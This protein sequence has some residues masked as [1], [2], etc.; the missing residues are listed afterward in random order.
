MSLPIDQCPSVAF[1]ADI[2][3]GQNP[4]Q[5]A[6]QAF[7]AKARGDTDLWPIIGE[8]N[9]VMDLTIT[10]LLKDDAWINTSNSL[11]VIVTAN[12][13]LPDHTH[14]LS[15]AWGCGGGGLKRTF[16]DI[17][18]STGNETYTQQST[19][20]EFDFFTLQPGEFEVFSLLFHCKAPGIYS[21]SLELPY[22]L[23]E[24]AGTASYRLERPIICPKSFTSWALEG[25]SFLFSSEYIWDGLRYSLKS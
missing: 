15:L 2:D 6:Q 4:S 5:A 14:A 22:T 23:A 11:N 17:D 9:L 24:K 10:S 13:V 19:S 21:L 1:P 20:S 7:E 3:P 16:S 25:E 12:P 8:N 18:L